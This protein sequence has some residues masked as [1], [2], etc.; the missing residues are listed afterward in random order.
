MLLGLSA[1]W[2]VLWFL[3]ARGFWE[4]DS[5]IH[6]EFARSLARGQGWSFNGHVVYGDTS[7]LW[8]G[9]L[10]LFHVALPDWMVAGKT[11][12]VVSAVVR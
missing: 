12:T 4:D 1:A 10:D 5:W 7:P 8:V 11:L 9:L 6:L 2:C 3:H